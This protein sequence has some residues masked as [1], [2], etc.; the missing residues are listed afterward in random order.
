[1]DSVDLVPFAIFVSG[2]VLIVTDALRRDRIDGEGQA[3]PGAIRPNVRDCRRSRVQICVRN[4]G[5]GL[6]FPERP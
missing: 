4:A 2:L 1:M 6:G 5:S 3:S